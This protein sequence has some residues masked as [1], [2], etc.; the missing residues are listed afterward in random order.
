MEV[1][2]DFPVRLQHISLMIGD[3]SLPTE[4]FDDFL[5]LS[6]V[7]PRHGW[8]QMVLDLATEGTEQEV[9]K[10]VSFEISR[11]EYLPA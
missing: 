6:L 11:G 1:L 9:G 3:G 5:C 10:G 8:E 2:Q 4:Y 7:V